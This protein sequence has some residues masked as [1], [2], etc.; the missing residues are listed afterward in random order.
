MTDDEM[1]IKYAKIIKNYCEDSDRCS[2]CPFG[3][4]GFGC[5]LYLDAETR[6][7]HNE[8]EQSEDVIYV[9]PDDQRTIMIQ[10]FITKLRENCNSPMHTKYCYEN[11]VFNEDS[12]CKLTSYPAEWRI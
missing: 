2:T 8:E 6:I 7:T 10:K 3:R 9:K 11:C 5:D 12:K 4:N 1:L